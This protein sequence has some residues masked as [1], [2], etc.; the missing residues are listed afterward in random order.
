M[1][2]E[3]ILQFGATINYAHMIVDE[4]GYIG[5]GKECW[6]KTVPLLTDVQREKLTARIEHWCELV[7]REQVRRCAS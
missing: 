1:T 3:H 5:Y 6:E 7:E 4:G 2:N